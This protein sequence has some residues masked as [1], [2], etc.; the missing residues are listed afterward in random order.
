M[1]CRRFRERDKERLGERKE[2]KRE[3]E[4]KTESERKGEADSFFF[5]LEILTARPATPRREKRRK[6]VGDAVE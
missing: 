1:G 4:R 2:R 5:F 3:R 6:V